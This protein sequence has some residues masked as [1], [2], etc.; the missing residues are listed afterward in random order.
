MIVH[1]SYAEP[2][3]QSGAV[4]ALTLLFCNRTDKNTHGNSVKMGF[5]YKG[6]F[7]LN[8]VYGISY[9]FL[10]VTMETQH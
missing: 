7:T 1:H 6:I 4:T 8:T 10:S 9:P 3:Q 2:E 5:W